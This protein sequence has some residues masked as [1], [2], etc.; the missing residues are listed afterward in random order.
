MTA[1]IYNCLNSYKLVVLYLIFDDSGA[2][3]V[4]RRSDAF[5]RIIEFMSS[6]VL[7]TVGLSA[8]ELLVLE[9]NLAYFKLRPVETPASPPPLLTWSDID[10]DPA[11]TLSNDK[12]TVESSFGTF[13]SYVYSNQTSSHFSVR[14]NTSRPGVYVG[15][16]TRRGCKGW[17]ID[18]SSGNVRALHENGVDNPYTSPLVAAD[19]VITAVYSHS[20]REISFERNGTALGT[21]F[22]NVDALEP[23]P[24]AIFYSGKKAS[25]TLL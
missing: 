20:R 22:A 1:V 4:D 11:F 15:F 8:Y 5:D 12:C 17:Y 25:L 10:L 14:L 16:S 6:G 18:T 2:Y 9:D 21:A 23:V 24:C 19:T 13:G 3:F 7:V